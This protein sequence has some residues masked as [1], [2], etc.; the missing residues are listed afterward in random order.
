MA[1]LSLSLDDV[2]KPRGTS[3]SKYKGIDRKFFPKWN[4]WSYIDNEMYVPDL[5]LREFFNIYFWAKL[6]CDYIDSQELASLLLTFAIDAG[7][8][9]AIM[10]LQRVIKTPITGIMS[11]DDIQKINVMDSSELFLRLYAEI[12]EFY[13]SMKQEV[14]L[15]HALCIYYKW[16]NK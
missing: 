7:K 4:G 9:K 12:I 13:I 1:K 5:E 2:L 16:L 14:N 15:S 11:I 6:K 8:K 10:K 3:S